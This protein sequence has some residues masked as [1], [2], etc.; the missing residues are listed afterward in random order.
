MNW[1]RA[2]VTAVGMCLALTV[3][4][5]GKFLK[6]K[7]SDAGAGT[8]TAT[9]TA[10]DLADEQMQDKLDEY[11]KC[12]N[13][14][15]SP[16]YKSR[17]RY[18]SYFPT[19]NITGKEPYADIYKLPAGA[20]ASCFAGVSKAQALPPTDPKLQGAGVEYATAAQA[21]DAL[22]TTE[23]AY[24][25][26]KGYK[27]D[28][29]AKGKVMHPQLVAAWKRF[30]A[31]DHAL[32]EVVDGITKPL[33]L[34]TLA[35]IEREDGKKFRWNRKHVL[36]TGRDLIEASDPTGE[37]TDIDFNLFNQTY[38][39]FEKALDDLSAYGGMHKADLSNQALAPS[40]PMADSNFT[41]F[42]GKANDFKKAAKEFWRCLRDAP[43]K[44]KTPSGKIDRSKIGNCSD[45]SVAWTRSD[46]T[47]KQYNDFIK[48]S[49]N[50]PFP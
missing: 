23:A 15:S 35:R 37:D 36:I 48:T 13:S 1:E 29:W 30:S 7:G 49:N 42:T 39:D 17:N 19:G 2:S 43:P 28:K 32:H 6:K 31:A 24:L 44:S 46:E 18:N 40:W 33:A 12:L 5:C 3:I 34:R 4:S 26:A 45:S 9:A 27:D 47:V 8:T 25:D 10:Q 11:I 16:I 21:V 14:L 20:S 41:A 50:Q 22:V 38:T